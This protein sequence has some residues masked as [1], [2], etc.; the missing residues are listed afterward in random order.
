MYFVRLF[1]CQMDEKW[2]IIQIYIPPTSE[3]KHKWKTYQRVTSLYSLLPTSSV[4]ASIYS[5]WTFN[6]AFFIS[7]CSSL[8]QLT[9]LKESD[10]LGSSTSDSENVVLQ[11]PYALLKLHISFC[12]AWFEVEVTTEYPRPLCEQIVSY[13]A[14][15]WCAESISV[16]T[17]PSI[18]HYY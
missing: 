16:V 5:S 11:Y 15:R 17:N 4:S 14:G 3:A 1:V 12:A 8:L 13:H 9:W 10:R 18:E 7:V 6:W 2:L